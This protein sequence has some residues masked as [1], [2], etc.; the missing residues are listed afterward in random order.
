MKKNLLAMA[1]H[2]LGTILGL[3]TAGYF[4]GWTA[5]RI[6]EAAYFCVCGMVVCCWRL[7]QSK[8]AK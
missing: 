3:A 2:V 8:A 5:Y 6:A 1:P 7:S 4:I